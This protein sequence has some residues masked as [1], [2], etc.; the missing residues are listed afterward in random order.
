MDG[1]G[2]LELPE[3]RLLLEDLCERRKGHR[4]VLE[5]EVQQ[6]MALMDKDGNGEVSVFEFRDTFANEHLANVKVLRMGDE[7]PSDPARETLA[8]RKAGGL[9]GRVSRAG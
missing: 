3:V 6:A 9:A 7:L 2:M 4:N 8:G 1:S 5:E